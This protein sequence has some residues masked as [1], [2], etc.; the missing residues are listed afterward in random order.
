MSDKRRFK[1]NSLGKDNFLEFKIRKSNVST[2][3]N[4]N[5]AKFSNNLSNQINASQ[6]RQ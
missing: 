4:Y 6:M 2:N 1:I 5:I 3:L